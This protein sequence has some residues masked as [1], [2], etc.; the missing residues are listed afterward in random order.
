MASCVPGVP[1]FRADVDLGN[2][3]DE[4]T[5]QLIQTGVGT[6]RVPVGISPALG[7]VCAQCLSLIQVTKPIPSACHQHPCLSAFLAAAPSSGQTWGASG[8][9]GDWPQEAG[10]EGEREGVVRRPVRMPKVAG[11]ACAR[12]QPG[13]WAPPW[14]VSEQSTWGHTEWRGAS[15]TSVPAPLPACRVHEEACSHGQGSC[16]VLH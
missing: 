7:Q 11:P 8:L 15:G 9:F 4:V 6:T 14:A 12:A 16:H 10:G 2:G 13:P 1:E 5:R 3:G